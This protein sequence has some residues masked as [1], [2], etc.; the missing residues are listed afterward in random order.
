[1]GFGFAPEGIENNEVIYELLSDAAW[2]TKEIDLDAWLKGYLTARYGS[3][4]SAMVEAWKLLRES[5]Y[6][7]FNDHPK[8]T[9]Q[10]QSWDRGCTVNRS[11]KV[12]AAALLVLSCSKELGSEPLYRA[13]AI[14]VSMMALGIR[15]QDLL[16]Q[17][18]A[19]HPNAPQL[20][21]AKAKEFIDLL[22]TIDRL[23]ESHPLHR[24]SRWTGWARSHGK[25][26]ALKDYYESNA[27]R[28]VT[29]WGG[30]L[31]DYAARLW[32]G[33]IRDYYIPRYQKL[34]EQLQTGKTIDVTAWE[35]TWVMTPGVSPMKPFSDPLGAARKALE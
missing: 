5:M 22:R 23:L 7:T 10:H 28:I 33:L 18:K 9:W 32:S 24:L 1:M 6:G 8:F 4:P 14:E 17:A 27:K 25:N 30:S 29:T 15:A 13:D 34:F 19:A 26:K 16:E 35:E 31:S 2:T 21:D 12:R 11:P 3:C 20:R